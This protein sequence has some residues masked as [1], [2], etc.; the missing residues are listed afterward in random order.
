MHLSMLSP[1]VGDGGWGRGGGYAWEIDSGS[2]PLGRDFDTQ[3]LQGREFDM[4]AIL[5]DR[6]NL[7]MSHPQSWY[8][9]EVTRSN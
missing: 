7:K 8:Y 5:E 1:R 9:T 6:E 2:F 3:S 4:A